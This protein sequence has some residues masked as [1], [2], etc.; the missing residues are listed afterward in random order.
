MILFDKFQK[1][2]QST[3]F[4]ESD[5][6]RRFTSQK[7]VFKFRQNLK[8]IV[9]VKSLFHVSFPSCSVVFTVLNR[10]LQSVLIFTQEVQTMTFSWLMKYFKKQIQGTKTQSIWVNVKIREKRKEK[11]FMEI[12]KTFSPKASLL[13]PTLL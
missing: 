4:C 5:F 11:T 3:N 2:F 9:V 1:F 10:I 8:N 12:V 7:N 13:L 6:P